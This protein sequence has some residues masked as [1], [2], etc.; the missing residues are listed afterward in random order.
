MRGYTTREVAELLGIPAP[1]IRSVAR[2]GL[3]SPARTPGGHYRFSF[4]DI[5]LLR[6][7][8]ELDDAEI[9]PRKIWRTVR[10]LKQQLPHGQSLTAV[11]IV[12][13]SDKVLVRDESSVWHPESGQTQFDF[14]VADLADQAIPMVRRAATDA[15]RDPDSKSEDWYRLGLDFETVSALEDAKRAYRR[16]VKLDPNHAEAH[17]NLGRLLQAE[18]EPTGAKVHYQSA[19]EVAPG[20]ATAVFNLGTVLEDLGHDEAAIEAYKQAINLAADF[21]D[22][23][24][25]LAR[26]YENIGDK[27]SA[28]RHLSRYKAL[29]A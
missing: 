6:T 4:Q 20:D 9:H 15:A 14:A 3:I 11:R 24:Y 7:A 27:R 12:A 2:K 17:I 28:V 10:T 23:H 19:I 5:I 16:A 26:L 25:N 21:A 13:E 8:K 1:R 22:A 29:T 18:G